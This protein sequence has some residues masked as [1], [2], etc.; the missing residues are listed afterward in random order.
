M[1]NMPYG[2]L[3]KIAAFAVVILFIAMSGATIG[4]SVIAAENSHLGIPI[5]SNQMKA[6]DSINPNTENNPSL[7]NRIID[8]NWAGYGFFN[9]PWY[10]FGNPETID[11]ASEYVHVPNSVSPAPTSETSVGS[12]ISGWIALSA[13]NQGTNMWQSGFI[14]NT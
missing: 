6:S 10:P 3:I 7:I 1:T 9:M 8:F 2:K 5:H 14:V 11:W 4:K 12:C 13:N